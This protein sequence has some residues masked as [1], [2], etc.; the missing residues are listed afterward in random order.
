VTW[1]FAGEFNI[2]PG[3]IEDF[4][5]GSSNFISTS[6]II[7]YGQDMKLHLKILDYIAILV[8]LVI[9]LSLGVY[10]YAGS[11]GPLHVQIQ[12]EE[13]TYVYTLEED[14]RVAVEGPIGTTYVE[15]HDGHAAIVESPCPNKLCIQA[16]RLY[17]HGDGSACM[18]NRIFVRI[19][20]GQGG[21]EVDATTY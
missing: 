4:S 10:V 18:P 14:R 16:G 11:D 3:L 12:T 6:V 13:E 7:V 21:G 5:L 8:S 2:L 19:E 17:N 1:F 9:T 20:G 15:I